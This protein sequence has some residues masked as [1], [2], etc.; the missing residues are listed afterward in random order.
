MDEP[1]NQYFFFDKSFIFKITAHEVCSK[2]TIIFLFS[3]LTLSKQMG[4]DR[5]FASGIISEKK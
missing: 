2:L 3:L 1:S 4:F 5:L